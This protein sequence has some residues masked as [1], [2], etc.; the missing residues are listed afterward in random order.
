MN[1]IKKIEL[2]FSIY[3][4]QLASNNKI[5]FYFFRYITFTAEWWMYVSYGLILL[6]MDFD[7]AIDPIKVG[8]IAYTFHYLI[9]YLI[10]NT[11]KRQRP[12]NAHESI[13]K[14]VIPPDKYSLPSGHSSG[15]TITTLIIIHFFPISNIEILFVWPLLIGMSRIMLGVHYLSDAIVGITLGYLSYYISIML[16]NLI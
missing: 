2:E 16:L 4:N 8:I 14:L 6:L 10:K 9:Y 1:T 5:I 12:F 7:E 15:A 11:F 13:K 3:C